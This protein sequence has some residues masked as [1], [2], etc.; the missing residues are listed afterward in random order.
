MLPY[1]WTSSENESISWVQKR[2]PAARAINDVRL[3][4]RLAQL[5]LASAWS[6]HPVLPRWAQA[7]HYHKQAGTRAD[8][9]SNVAEEPR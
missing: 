1:S 3:T 2:I 8:L 9:C 6:D 7:F 5:K 4:S